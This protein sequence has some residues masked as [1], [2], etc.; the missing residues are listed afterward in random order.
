L[1]LLV[2]IFLTDWDNNV[3]LLV[4]G[5]VMP[6]VVDGKDLFLWGNGLETNLVDSFLQRKQFLILLSTQNLKTFSFQ[7]HLPPPYFNFICAMFY[8]VIIIAVKLDF[9]TCS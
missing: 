7:H 5:K 1:G 3:S 6:L 9:Y 4:V 2:D 8:T